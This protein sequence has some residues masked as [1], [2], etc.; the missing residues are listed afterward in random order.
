[1]TS[2]LIIRLPQAVSD[3]FKEYQVHVSMILILCLVHLHDIK[4]I[5]FVIKS[6]NMWLTLHNM[7]SPLT[8][9]SD[10]ADWNAVGTFKKKNLSQNNWSK[11]LYFQVIF[12]F[13]VKE[14]NSIVLIQHLCWLIMF[15]SDI[16]LNIFSSRTNL[17]WNSSYLTISSSFIETIIL[18]KQNGFKATKY[19]S[20]QRT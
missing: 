6:K 15:P 20:I 18:K 19:Y 17:T 16:K 4:V 12:I 2:L 9:L 7:L 1:M 8:G 10:Y 14:H 3:S 13:S 11:A 5:C